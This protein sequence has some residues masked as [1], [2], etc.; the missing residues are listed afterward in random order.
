[1]ETTTSNEEHAQD[2]RVSVNSRNIWTEL[3]RFRRAKNLRLPLAN[4]NSM[5]GSRPLSFGPRK[6][7][8][9][10]PETTDEESTMIAEAETPRTRRPAG[11][12]G[13]V[14]RFGSGRRGD[15]GSQAPTRHSSPVRSIASYGGRRS[16]S[17]G[18]RRGGPPSVSAASEGDRLWT[19]LSRF[20][21][22]R[23]L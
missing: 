22:R 12:G 14:G 1:V 7:I 10:A 2:C 3:M 17:P 4:R 5:S 6:T 23:P 15:D 16:R 13:R 19:A 11:Y 8:V 21:P 18:S 20:G 9:R